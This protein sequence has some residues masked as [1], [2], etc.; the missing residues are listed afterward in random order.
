M[1]PLLPKQTFENER[2][3]NP[4]LKTCMSKKYNKIELADM[5]IQRGSIIQKMSHVQMLLLIYF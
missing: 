2:K 1:D 5:F 3:E 4:G